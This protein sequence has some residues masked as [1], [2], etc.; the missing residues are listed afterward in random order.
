MVIIPAIDLR[1]GC[2]VRL[3][4]GD[5]GR[6]TVYDQDPLAVAERFASMG[7][8]RLHLVDLD[9]AKDGKP[10]HMSIVSMIAKKL[11]IPVEIG[12]GI[13]D[14]ETIQAYLEAGI[15]WIILGSV[16]V[17]K[18]QMVEEACRIYPGRIIVGIDAREGYVATRGWLED[19]KVS[20]LELAGRMGSFGVK[21]IIYTDIARDG[22]LTGPN[23]PALEEMARKSGLSVIASGGV[24]SLVDLFA[25]KTLEPLGVSGVIVGKAIYDGRLD[26]NEAVRRIEGVAED[27]G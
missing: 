15:Q 10:S 8:K 3:Q 9:G 6:E 27:A 18:P 22:M 7:A 1:N 24:G 26:L 16:A 13:R 5:Y 17:E 21:E 23:L 2:C 14:L 12:G 4:Q 19:S 11:S 25:L 20:A